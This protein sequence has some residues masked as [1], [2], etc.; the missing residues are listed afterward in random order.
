MLIRGS[1]LAAAASLGLLA[2][3]DDPPEEPMVCGGAQAAAARRGP[4]QISES[5][6]D[7]QC[8]PT[9]DFVPINSYAGE[10]ASVQDREG[11]VVLIDGRCTR[12][13]IVAAAGPVVM[14]AGHCVSV[15]EQTLVVFNFEDAPD[16]D[17]LIT[18]GTV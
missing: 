10:I 11:A 16:G 7:L 14:T 18:Q 8:G 1:L 13:L 3:G 4:L 15:G 9:L 2:C 6:Q 12:T 5:I 17:P